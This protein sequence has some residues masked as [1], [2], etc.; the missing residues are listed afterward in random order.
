MSS[1]KLK[2]ISLFQKGETVAY[3][4]PS[5]PDKRASAI[6]TNVGRGAVDAKVPVTK[7]LKRT[8]KTC[9]PDASVLASSS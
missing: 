2:N 8:A 3:V 1:P 7:V 5:R 4:L 9:G 6:V